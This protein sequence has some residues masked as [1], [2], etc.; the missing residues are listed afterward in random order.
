MI[1]LHQDRK[2]ELVAVAQWRQFQRAAGFP[3]CVRARRFPP[4]DTACERARAGRKTRWPWSASTGSAAKSPDLVVLDVGNGNASERDVMKLLRGRPSAQFIVL[5]T[6]SCDKTH[7]LKIGAAY[8]LNKPVG[9]V[10]LVE[11]CNSALRRSG[12]RA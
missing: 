3:R 11:R 2:H 9:I 5:S 1:A 10:E 6:E 8:H 12:Q 7:F 4:D